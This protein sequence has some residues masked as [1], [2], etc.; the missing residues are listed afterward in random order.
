MQGE[1]SEV[2]FIFVICYS[3]NKQSIQNSVKYFVE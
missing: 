2:M 3:A 1:V